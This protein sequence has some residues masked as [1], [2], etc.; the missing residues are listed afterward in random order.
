MFGDIRAFPPGSHPGIIGLDPDKSTDFGHGRRWSWH[1][2]A[3]T[4][5]NL[6]PAASDRP[7]ATAPSPTLGSGW[8]RGVSE[9][10]V[11]AIQSRSD[12]R[13][14]TP[15][16]A[17]MAPD[18]GPSDPPIWRRRR[19][20]NPDTRLCRTLP[21]TASRSSEHTLGL[22]KGSLRG[23]R[24]AGQGF[25]TAND[26]Q[27][28]PLPHSA[29]PRIS[30]HKERARTPARRALL[31]NAVST[32]RGSGDICCQRRRVVGFSIVK[33]RRAAQLGASA[34]GGQCGRL[35]SGRT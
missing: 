18:L 7:T 11:A 31:L 25:V 14:S 17:K 24:G 16:T 19:E 23:E 30:T 13:R 6:S 35:A 4:H 21:P 12:R 32:D 22:T 1:R 27:R 10:P 26:G 5:W 34:P 8:T 20:S 9:A 29:R 33:F 3:A 15:V 2:S 28:G